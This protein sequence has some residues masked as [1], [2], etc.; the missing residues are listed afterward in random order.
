MAR[1]GQ[2]G[3]TFPGSVTEAG[4]ID[5]GDLANAVAAEVETQLPAA[6]SGKQDTTAKN[7]ANGYAGLD[8]NALLDPDQIPLADADSPG[9]M[10]AADFDKLDGIEAGAEAN[11]TAAEIETAYDNQV[12]AVSQ[13]EAEAGA[14][15]AIRRW[16]PER[17]GQ[18]IAALAESAMPTQADGTLTGRAVGAGSG[19]RQQLSPA[20]GREV[21]GIQVANAPPD[22]NY[23]PQR[24]FDNDREEYARQLFSLEVTVNANVADAYIV[25][26]SPR[27]AVVTAVGG[28]CHTAAATADLTF[29]IDNIQLTTD[30]ATFPATDSSRTSLEA[31]TANGAMTPGSALT[32]TVANLSSGLVTVIVHGYLGRDTSGDE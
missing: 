10:S 17:V 28:F 2:P 27:N 6:I 3:G 4:E 8:A 32:Y 16:S 31:V 13:A 9:A 30:P 12:A 14:E 24:N 18:A 7:Q 25:S 11:P 1:A 26:N 20:Q 21:M 23:F 29:E 5:P 22:N 19:A 15:V